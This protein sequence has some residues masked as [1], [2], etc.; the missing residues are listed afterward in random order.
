MTDAPIPIPAEG[1]WGGDNSEIPNWDTMPRRNRRRR[2][3][4][5]Y[6]IWLK[7][8]GSVIGLAVLVTAAQIGVHAVRSDPRDALVFAERELE[9][10]VLHPNEKVLATVSVWQ[11]PAIDYFRPTRGILVVTDAPGDSANPVGGRLIYLGLQPRDP[12]S[13]PD[14]PPTFDEREWPLDTA[15][16]VT[17]TRTL[18]YLSR[19]ISIAAPREKLTVGVPSPASGNADAVL[20]AVAKK[21]GLLRAV[22]WQRREARRAADREQRVAAQ[23]GRR[24]WFHTV[25]RGEALASV[26]KMFNTTADEVRSLN[27]IT[28][29]KIKL[30]QRL[31][32]KGRTK[33]PV[34]PPAGVV[35]EYQP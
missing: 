27:G 35:P 24:E 20:A 25:R 2:R 12:L 11:R 32:V 15:V 16:V 4:G 19:A 21:Y 18:F 33:K 8:L 31:K 26:A 17:P 7:Y 5:G 22:G 3:R 23:Q 30:G 13:R 28:G 9:L 10:S 34:L 6:P 1:V 14:S 29:D